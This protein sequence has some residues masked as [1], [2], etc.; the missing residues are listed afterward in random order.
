LIAKRLGT[1]NRGRGVVSVL[2]LIAIAMLN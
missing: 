1:T 2:F